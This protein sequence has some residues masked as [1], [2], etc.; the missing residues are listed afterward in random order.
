V[1][2]ALYEANPCLIAPLRPRAAFGLAARRPADPASAPW[3]PPN[4][5][6][7]GGRDPARQNFR[8]RTLG[9][10]SQTRNKDDDQRQKFC[11]GVLT[12]DPRENA[13][14]EVMGDLLNIERQEA[15]LVWR[16]QSEG[17]P[18]E[19]RS[20]CAPLAILQC[21]LVTAAAV[22][23]SPGSSPGMSWDMRRRASMPGL[24]RG[25]VLSSPWPVRLVRTW[26]E[27]SGRC[28]QNGR[29]IEQAAHY[30]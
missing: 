21:R 7:W 11:R 10:A 20:D 26:C 24:M 9:A 27:Q 25:G 16:G 28:L 29:R 8:R 19:H 30:G 12:H 23:A 1:I 15:A 5:K 6:R 14:A 13:E 22:T 17:L 3:H 4:A 2:G 18:V